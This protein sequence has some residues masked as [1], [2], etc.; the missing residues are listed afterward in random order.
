MASGS[1]SDFV[2]FSF[3]QSGEKQFMTKIQEVIRQ[4]QWEIRVSGPRSRPNS[5]APKKLRSGIGG[6]EKSMAAKTLKTDTEISKAF[7]DLDKLMEMAK[8][9]VHLAKNISGKIKV[10][11]TRKKWRHLILVIFFIK[12]PQEKQG[13]ISDNETVQFKSYL[14][15]LGISD[16]VTRE[17]HGSERNYYKELAKEV[18]RILDQPVQVT[19]FFF[20]KFQASFHS[21]DIT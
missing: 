14:L 3:K 17:A 4:K 10:K 15:S 12:F 13:D 16:P 5:A 2:K 7:Q 11:T 1:S 18:F 20:F 9:M 21:W 6:I 19:I 8:P